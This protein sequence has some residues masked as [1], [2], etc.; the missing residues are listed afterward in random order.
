MSEELQENSVENT[1]VEK[2]EVIFHK[3]SIFEFDPK[4]DLASIKFDESKEP[5]V[6]KIPRLPND[7]LIDGEQLDAFISSLFPMTVDRFTKSEPAKNANDFLKKVKVI[8]TPEQ[9]V[10]SL[11]KIEVIRT[12]RNFLLDDSDWTQMPDSNLS[13]EKKEEWRKYRKALRD[14][15]QRYTGFDFDINDVRFPLKPSE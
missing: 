5:I 15:P 11:D 13:K 12:K 6:T 2:N 9:E 1:D 7:N 3:Y 14:L 4:T 10:P 8:K